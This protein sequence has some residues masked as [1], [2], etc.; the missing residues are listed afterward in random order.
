[1]GTDQPAAGSDEPRGPVRH[2]RRSGRLQYGSTC[3]LTCCYTSDC[4]LMRN[5]EYTCQQL[6]TSHDRAKVTVHLR[7][8][9]QPAAAGGITKGDVRYS[10][11]RQHLPGPHR[12]VRGVNQAVLLFNH[13]YLHGIF[14]AQ[15]NLSTRRTAMLTYHPLK[16]SL[17][18]ALCSH[19]L[20]DDLGTPCDACWSFGDAPSLRTN[21]AFPAVCWVE[22]SD[23]AM[24][25]AVNAAPPCILQVLAAARSC[26]LCGAV[27][28]WLFVSATTYQPSYL[29][30]EHTVWF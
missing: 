2:C 24:D 16:D 4:M 3:G 20:N 15:V 22:A 9:D 14:V 30:R 23:A 27:P 1:M 17:Q 12:Y 26:K 19:L 8:M 29:A 5:G 21:G 11:W 18:N 25:A 13:K 28:M 10:K 6:A 7:A